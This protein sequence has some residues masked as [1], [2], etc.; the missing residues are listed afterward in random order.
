MQ[1]PLGKRTGSSNLF[2]V[3]QFAS[4]VR[5]SESAMPVNLLGLSIIKA[6]LLLS[7]VKAT[8]RHR[9]GGIDPVSVVLQI[10]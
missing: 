1:L 8:G 4:G 5:Q 2:E 3:N 9:C 6:C 10:K 7:A